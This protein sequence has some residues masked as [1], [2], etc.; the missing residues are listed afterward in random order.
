MNSEFENAIASWLRSQPAF[1]GV[2]V[3]TGQS[4]EEIP[5]DQPIVVVSCENAESAVAGLYRSSVQITASTPIVMESAI[6]LHRVLTTSL[7]AL[8]GLSGVSAFFPATLAFSGRHLTSWS[9]AR[10]NDRLH[11]T[12]EIVIGVR[13]I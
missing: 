12:A 9:E 7:R 3:H 5:G 11:T 1:D 8:V 4:S 13:E 2:A 10:E 6:E